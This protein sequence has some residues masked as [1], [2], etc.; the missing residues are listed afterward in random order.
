MPAPREVRELVELFREHLAAYKAG[1]FNEAQ[2][3]IQF[4]NPLFELLGWDIAN[5]SGAHEAFKEVI[6]EASVSVDGS[7]RAPDYCFRLGGVRKFFLEAKKPSVNIGTDFAPAFQLRR[8]GWSAKLDISVLTDFE[9]LAIYDCRVR[10]KSDEVAGTAR[11]L[12]LKYTDFVDQWD[13]LIGILGRDSVERGA[14]EA[15]A[16]E[17]KKTRGREQVDEVF[18]KDIETWRE[19]LAKNIASRNSS[20]SVR[21]LNS[22]VQLTIDRIV[23]LRIAEDR[24]IEKH[25]RLRDV[26]DTPSVYSRLVHLFRQ[27]DD[28]Y[29]SGLFHFRAGDGSPETVDT[30]TLG[31]TID[32]KVLRDI[33]RGLYFPLSPYAF[34]VIPADILGQVYEQFLGKVI[35][36]KG[37]SAVVEE[38]PDVK[39]AGG[40]YYTPSH[41]V[42]HIV[43]L[44]VDKALAAR[45]PSSAK[46]HP[47]RILDPACGSG[48]F[49]IVAYQHIL[50]WHLGHYAADDPERHA[51]GKHPKIYKASNGDWR[52]T[53][54][55]RRRILLAHI[56]GV[57]IDPQAV[58]VTKLS[59]LLKVLEGESGDAI[60]NQ[61]DLFQTRALPDLGSNIKCGNS[62]IESDFY[63]IYNPTLFTLDQRLDVNTFDWDDEFFKEWGTRFDVVIGNPPY[64]YSAGKNHPEYFQTRYSTY[65]YQTDFYQYFV[66]KSYKLVHDKGVVSFIIP[67][68]WTNLQYFTNLRDLMIFKNKLERITIFDYFVFKKANIENTIFVTTPSKRNGFEVERSASPGEFTRFNTLKTK[69]IK[70]L[71]IVDPR[72][73]PENEAI[74]KKVDAFS[75]LEATFDINRGLHAYRTDGYGKSKFG[76]GTQTKRDK[77][78]RSYHST[79]KLNSTYLPEVR[80]RDVGRFEYES[81]GEYISY[82]DWLAEPRLPKYFKSPKVVARKTLGPKLS[83]CYIKE[84]AAVDQ[85]LY[86]LLS[87]RNDE[88]ELS[89]VLGI[90]G[91][92]IG[93]WYLR[94]KH[95]IYDLL[96]PWY[97]KKQLA[98]FPFPKKT[99]KIVSALAD[100]IIS[101][102]ARTGARL[103]Q[104]RKLRD[105]D[106]ERHERLLDDAVFDAYGLSTEEREIVRRT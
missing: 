103:E 66:E 74:I 87:K 40:V 14:I 65:E 80:G 47:L 31:L 2:V 43:S 45:K 21:E 64:L 60:A 48:S 11:L 62:L 105:K 98:E 78:E 33:I 51:K 4:I 102:N 85:A 24:G 61:M 6:H 42:E 81:S 70:R 99:D 27:A 36:L 37:R 1:S 88:T 82:G 12:L 97:T 19:M 100:L 17:T 89:A 20:L 57:D 55:E 34:S 104:E 53:I 9:E 58:E 76:P 96:H 28:R 25:G 95:A 75:K 94:T 49:L 8:Y 79:K 52:L 93:A 69:D 92:S 101:R 13:K 22:A 90:L 5:A 3:R 83:C 16:G 26:L 23:F 35:R 15:F 10:P 54:A 41:I 86:I 84:P 56:F 44:T 71:G 59:L 73:R 67:D 68:S 106:V 39:K 32:D 30:F 77:D 50:D 29:N 7:A 63:S 46:S 18:L 72:Y 91:S 38:K